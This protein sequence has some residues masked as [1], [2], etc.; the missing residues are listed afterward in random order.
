V[1]LQDGRRN[2]HAKQGESRAVSEKRFVMGVDVGSTAVKAVALSERGDVAAEASVTCGTVSPRPGWVE[3]DPDVWWQA[4][5]T[6]I[7]NCLRQVPA[8][9][10]E[11]VSFSGHMSA[12]VLVDGDGNPVMPSIMIADTRSREETR[13]LRETMLPRILAM[14]G[15]EPLDAFALAKLLWIRRHRPDAMEK[16]KLLLFPK[17]YIRF[18]LTGLPGTDP[19]DAGNSQMYHFLNKGWDYG[20]LAD[21]GLD[22]HLLPELHR[23][24]AVVGRVHREAA[25]WT[26]LPEGTPVV[27]GAADMACSQIGTG[28]VAEGTLAITLS[29]SAQVVMRVPS[30]RT[31][32]PGKIT[33]HPS[34]VPDTFYAMGSMF[35]GGLG[36]EW[37]YR[38]LSGKEK[39]EEGDFQ[40]ING[41]CR[42]MACIPPGSEGLM[43]L[44]FLT[45]SGTP[46]YDAM[47][48]ASWLG[49][50][51]GQS[52]A[53][54]LHS[55]L[56]G[57]SF[58]I[59]ENVEMFESDG[60][61]IGRIHLGG[62][63]SNN[64]VWCRMIAHVLGKDIRLLTVRNA[65]AIG[66]AILAGTG[67]G[68][69]PSLEEAAA[70]AVKTGETFVPDRE[71][72]G[73]YNRLYRHYRK[74][75]RALNAHY[76]EWAADS[77]TE[78]D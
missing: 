67:T 25:G 66:A 41:L 17:D 75:Y 28:A 5:V 60:H 37:G 78:V 3:Q 38:F 4:A 8:D 10:I 22:R 24:D 31:G 65:S 71:K 33:F 69:F 74:I 52:K 54:M 46:Y 16:A 45:G 7:R 73:R 6:A 48:K 44:P 23:S 57:I 12:T 59:R 29:T 53:L 77:T 76:H 35:S 49:L 62:G 1:R 61:R 42:E 47:D 43:F 15:N 14:T 21:L 2:I 72:H 70:R 27:T 34:A 55:I 19:T 64:P 9:G 50:S 20:L 18:R 40:A 32:S 63:G 51:T 26:G 11:A 56:E 68:F 58:N 13:R 39:L 30:L 36:V